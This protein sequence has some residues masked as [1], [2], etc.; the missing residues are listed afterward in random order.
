M[1]KRA[2]MLV[3]ETTT[4]KNIFESGKENRLW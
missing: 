4:L 1:V 2:S 3:N